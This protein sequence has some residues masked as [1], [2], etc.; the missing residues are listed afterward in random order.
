M[1][2]WYLEWDTM[3]IVNEELGVAYET[4][5]AFEKPLPNDVFIAHDLNEWHE[6]SL[7]E[8]KDTWQKPIPHWFRDIVDDLEE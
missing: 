3:R 7:K 2:R 4:V 5:N 8:I 6:S 1:Y